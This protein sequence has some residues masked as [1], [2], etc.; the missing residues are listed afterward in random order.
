MEERERQPGKAGT[1]GLLFQKPCSN[2][3]KNVLKRGNLGK[4]KYE[5]AR[6]LGSR[7]EN[8]HFVWARRSREKKMDFGVFWRG[9]VTPS[10][11]K[12]SH[13]RRTNG[14]Q[15]REGIFER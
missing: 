10:L 7:R 12:N 3:E 2:Q 4:R 11:L 14:F 15:M 13:R 8:R 5:S 1:G 6:G 9:P